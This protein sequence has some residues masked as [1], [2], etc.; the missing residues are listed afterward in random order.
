[1]TSQSRG[2]HDRTAAWYDD[3]AREAGWFPQA[4]F[5]LC[6]D[7]MRPGQRLL[8]VGIGTGLCA[9]RSRRTG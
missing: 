5:G 1:M 8:S 2:A 9:A 3:A 4:L 6:F 7:R